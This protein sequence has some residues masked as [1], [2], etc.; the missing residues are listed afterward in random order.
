MHEPMEGMKSL[1]IGA[2]GT[3]LLAL[4]VTCANADGIAGRGSI[5]DGPYAAQGPAIH[6]WTGLYFGGHLGAGAFTNEWSIGPLD[7]PFGSGT[8]SGFLGGAQIG[9]NYQVGAIVVGLEA[10]V[11]WAG[12]SGETCAPEGAKCDSQTDRFGTLTGRFGI[13]TDRALFYVKGDA[14]WVH[15]TQGLTFFGGPLPTHVTLSGDKWGWTAGAGVEYALT[16][17]WSARLQYDFMD[18][19]T[20]PHV[21]VGP[22][23][24]PVT[25][26]DDT[27]INAST[28]SSSA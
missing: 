3:A 11:S 22:T 16:R 7:A 20:N 18:F 25:T 10:D 6:N 1:R 14:A 21:F 12:L 4:G 26:Q 8:A 2:L 15:D 27:L 28:Q 24:I 17:N 19:G 13:A 5:K 23:G 9:I